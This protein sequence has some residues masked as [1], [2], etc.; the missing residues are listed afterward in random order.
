MRPWDASSYLLFTLEAFK[1]SINIHLKP[2]ANVQ[3]I[4]QAYYT[5]T[6][7]VHRLTEATTVLHIGHLYPTSCSV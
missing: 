6:G 2:Q 1:Q 3:Q 5:G 7:F 4:L